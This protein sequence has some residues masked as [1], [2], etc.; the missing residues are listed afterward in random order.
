ML[1]PISIPLFLTVSVA[2][3]VTV[4]IFLASIFLDAKIDS[5][6]SSFDCNTILAFSEN[7]TLIVSASPK[8]VRSRFAPKLV[9][10][11]QSSNKVVIKPPEA[12]SCPATILSS[13]IKS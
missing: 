3:F 9:S 6:L 10:A 8:L 12:T 7:K 4:P 11:K 2:S 1:S 13:L 5:M